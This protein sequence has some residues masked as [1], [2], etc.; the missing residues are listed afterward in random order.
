MSQSR[1]RAVRRSLGTSG[2]TSSDQSFHIISPPL[3]RAGTIS[4]QHFVN[5]VDFNAWATDEVKNHHPFDGEFLGLS[6]PE[7]AWPGQNLSPLSSP[8]SSHRRRQLQHSPHNQHQ[9]PHETKLSRSYAGGFNFNYFRSQLRTPDT[10]NYPLRLAGRKYLPGRTPDRAPANRKI[11]R[12]A[13]LELF[14]SKAE[15]QDSWR[16]KQQTSSKRKKKQISIHHSMLD[17]SPI[18]QASA[19]LKMPQNRARAQNQK[20]LPYGPVYGKEAMYTGPKKFKHWEGST[21]L[22]GSR[23]G[24]LEPLGKEEKSFNAYMSQRRVLRDHIPT[25]KRT[26]LN[27]L[28][29]S[30]SIPN[31]VPSP[32]K[33]GKGLMNLSMHLQE[34]KH[35]RKHGLSLQEIKQSTEFAL[36]TVVDPMAASLSSSS[37]AH[38]TVT[39]QQTDSTTE[40]FS[41]LEGEVFEELRERQKSRDLESMMSRDRSRQMSRHENR[42][43]SITPGAARARF[44]DS[45]ISDSAPL[46]H[47]VHVPKVQKRCSTP[48]DFAH[49][50]MSMK[51]VSP[52]MKPSVIEIGLEVRSRDF[53][54]RGENNK[55][56]KAAKPWGQR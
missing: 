37:F 9:H 19:L 27:R 47:D 21:N 17:V 34:I 25:M 36:Q 26:V 31:L 8:N 56:A 42:H 4:Q 44:S 35:E 53:D 6:S 30:K 22:H 29:P 54:Y 1:H 14:S 16:Q 7:F 46:L 24:S 33:A 10:P 18:Q 43:R 55:L 45:V 38:N 50:R 32:V 52:Q 49:T 41:S 39:D 12:D 11:A 15:Q 13:V 48:I 40:V 51:A 2:T 23:S 28:R 3:S 20:P 5:D